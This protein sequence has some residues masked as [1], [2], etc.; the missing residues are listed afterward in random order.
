MNTEILVALMEKSGKSK[1]T[2]YRM[3]ERVMEESGY[4]IP[5][6][7]IAANVLAS[8]MGIKINEILDD[9]ELAEVR[10]YLTQ[11]VIRSIV[12]QTKTVERKEKKPTIKIGEEII[13]T[14]GLPANLAAEAKKMA[15]VY[16]YFYIFENSLRYIIMT[17]LENKHGKDWW[18]VENVVSRR[19]KNTVKSRMK[20]EG[21]KRWH[22]MKR[23][24]HEIFYTNFGD[25]NSIIA[26]NREDFEKIFGDINVIQTKLNEVEDMRNIIA[27]NNPLPLHEIERMRL[28][29]D[30]LQ[31]QLVG[32]VTEFL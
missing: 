1:R 13:E 25:L 5:H 29:F 32:T 18:N 28:Y 27:H 4:T 15:V 10:R 26:N 7:R 31:R 19:I 12:I 3:I 14:F 30:D 17:T 23:G 20:Q 24:R 16:P 22:G 21:E 9:D 2:V 8:K 6:K 11:P